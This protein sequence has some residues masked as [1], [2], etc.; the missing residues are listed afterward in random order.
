MRHAVFDRRRPEKAE[1]L[2]LAQRL[3]QVGANLITQG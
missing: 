3:D 2:R 1:T